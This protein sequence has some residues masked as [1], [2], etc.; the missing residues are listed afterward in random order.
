MHCRDEE[1]TALYSILVKGKG[2]V[3]RERGGEP[4][5]L[6]GIC[7]HGLVLCRTHGFVDHC[8]GELFLVADVTVVSWYRSPN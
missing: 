1:H 3:S 5:L 2:M 6:V 8:E 4:Y 7:T